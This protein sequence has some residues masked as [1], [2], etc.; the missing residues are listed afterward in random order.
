MDRFGYAR[1]IDL[2]TFERNKETVLSENKYVFQC[3]NTGKICFFTNT[4]QLHTLRY[5]IYGKT[6]EEAA[7][8]L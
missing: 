2:Q 5:L 1:T 6:Q 8:R 4:G 3:K 7:L